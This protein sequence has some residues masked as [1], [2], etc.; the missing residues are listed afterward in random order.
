MSSCDVSSDSRDGSCKGIA[1]IMVLGLLAVMLLLAVTFAISMRTERLAA[2][3]YADEVRARHL[4]HVGLAR[5]LNDL[6][7]DLGTNGLKDGGGKM[8]PTWGVTNSYSDMVMGN[9]DFLRGAATN[10][11]PRALWEE[12]VS[13]NMQDA[14]NHWILIHTDQL[15]GTNAAGN[16]IVN[17][18]VMGRV[19]YLIIDCSSLLDANYCGGLSRDIGYR[20]SEIIISNLGDFHDV[21]LFLTNR[22]TDV[23]YETLPELYKMNAAAFNGPPSNLFVYSYSPPG[24][25]DTNGV[26]SGPAVNLAGNSLYSRIEILNAFVDAGFSNSEAGLLWTNLCDYADEDNE[27]YGENRTPVGHGL[28]YSESVPMINEIVCKSEDAGPNTVKHT[29][30]IELWNPYIKP[31]GYNLYFVMFNCNINDGATINTFSPNFSITQPFFTN[32][33]FSVTKISTPYAPPYEFDIEAVMVYCMSGGGWSDHSG[34]TIVSAGPMVSLQCID[35]RFNSNL[36]DTNQWVVFQNRHTLGGMNESTS[37]FWAAH[38]DCDRDMK[39]YVADRSLKTV[40][41]LGYLAYAPWKTIRLTGTN[42]SRV[43]SVFG[44]ATNSTQAYLTNAYNL[45]IIR[46][47]VNCNT[48]SNILDPIV[49]VFDG[50]PVD[51][52]PEESGAMRLNMTDGRKIAQRIFDNGPYTNLSD[53]YQRMTNFSGLSVAVTNKFLEDSFV[54]NTCGLLTTRQN[55]FTLIIEAQVAS[56]GNFPKRPAK[57]RAVAVVWRDPFTGTMFVRSLIW[58]KD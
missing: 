7:Q 51:Q 11:I 17:T 16:P 32:C 50:M 47:R 42:G 34:Y 56:G 46:G 21:D 28:S 40:G 44:L 29:V 10:Y 48:H 8:I 39:M 55:L 23:R 6:A 38:P 1:L 45:G 19:G 20:S 30:N 25:W 33:S 54:R 37:N 2:G 52:Y 27:P 3:N 4:I 41:E 43:T 57:Q 31:Y 36:Y 53:M 5:A 26:T 35:P 9:V 49:A 15:V 58:L 22:A 12:A 13:A 24:Y 14:S 18:N